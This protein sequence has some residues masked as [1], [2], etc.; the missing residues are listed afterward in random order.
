MKDKGIRSFNTLKEDL[1]K[2]RWPILIGLFALIVVDLLQLLIPRVVKWAIDDLASGQGDSSRLLLYG[3][4]ILVLA[5]GIGGFRYLWRY[6]LLGASRRVEMALRER[7]FSHLQTLSPSYFSR[8]KIGDLMAHALNDIEAVRMA[9][10]LGLVFLVDTIVLGILSLFF[11][12]YIHPL[13]TF[14]AVLP[15]PLIA[16]VALFFSRTIHRRYEV[17]QRAFSQLTETVREAIAGIRVIRAYVLEEVEREKLSQVGMDYIQKNVSLTRTWGIF[18]PLLLFLS[19]LSLALVLYLGGRLTIL[20]SISAGDFVAFMSYLGM[21][22]WPMM[23]IGWAINMIQRGA[24]S[25]GRIN[26]ILAETPE[27]SDAPQATFLGP[28]RG[29]IEVRGLT[30]SPKNGGPPILEDVHLN[31]RPGEKVAIVGRTGSGKTVLCQLLVRMLESPEGTIF[32]DG[33]EIHQIPLKVLRSSIGYVPQETFLFSDTVRE[34][35]AF[36]RPEATL[37]EIEE[38]ARLAQIHDEIKEFPAGL[39]T[40]IGEKGITLSGGQRQRIAIARAVL[41]NA[42]IFILDDALSSVDL[43]TE[44]KILEGLETF[45]KGRTTLLIT[46]RI[47]PL[48]KADR[49]IVLEKGRVAEMGDHVTLLSRGGLYAKLYWERTMEEEMER[50]R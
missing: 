5:L 13:L 21:L 20:F 38:A 12:V 10:A 14:Y 3:G 9:M 41:M 24:A 29:G 50:D 16:A 44:E 1:F 47:A 37:K 45:L 25:M 19:N 8:T 15:M 18:F 27:I 2:N 34:N 28:L 30:V 35:I 32:Y 48:R 42:P 11:M 33:H 40:V 7:F 39:D 17:L 46:H 6:L 31:L 23:A 22:S 43:Q 36:G 4:Q 49:I 26:R